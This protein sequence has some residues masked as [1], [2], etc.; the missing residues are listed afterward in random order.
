MCMYESLALESVVL[1]CKAKNRGAPSPLGTATSSRHYHYGLCFRSHN[2]VTSNM[3]LVKLLF[4][5]RVGVFLGGVPTERWI[6]SRIYNAFRVRRSGVVCR[7]WSLY[8]KSSACFCVIMWYD[9]GYRLAHVPHSMYIHY[10]QS[11]FRSFV[12]YGFGFSLE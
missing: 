10:I 4:A 1:N 5:P 9:G 11:R 6:F 3:R 8:G 7:G 2:S 12:L